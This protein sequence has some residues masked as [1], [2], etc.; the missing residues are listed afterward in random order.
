MKTLVGRAQEAADM[1]IGGQ[2]EAAKRCLA[3]ARNAEAREVRQA[4][5]RCAERYILGAL[6]YERMG[7]EGATQGYAAPSP[8]RLMGG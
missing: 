4:L 2:L 3:A 1:E 7:I 6:G 5:A 8:C